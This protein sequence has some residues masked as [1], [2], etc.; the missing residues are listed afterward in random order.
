MSRVESW[1]R[2]SPTHSSTSSEALAASCSS[3][4]FSDSSDC[5][6]P[7]LLTGPIEPW[8]PANIFAQA[9]ETPRWPPLQADGCS[10]WRFRSSG[11]TDML[12]TMHLGSVLV[13]IVIGLVL[14]APIGWSFSRRRQAKSSDDLQAPLPQREA[15]APPPFSP[16]AALLFGG[17]PL[18]AA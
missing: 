18:E 8:R 13:G 12:S 4:N 5:G 17:A 10:R 2:F 9:C 1:S 7:H 16:W 14:G 15:A 6:I 3:P 11:A